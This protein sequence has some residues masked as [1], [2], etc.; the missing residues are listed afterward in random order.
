M[1]DAQPWTDALRNSHQR[2]AKL[3]ADLGAD[4]VRSPSYANGPS[5]TSCPTSA[6]AP[7]TAPS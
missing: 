1:S 5:R 3:A 6:A 4:D 2:L 7:N